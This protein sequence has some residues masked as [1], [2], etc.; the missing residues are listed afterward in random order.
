MAEPFQIT[1]RQIA[2]IVVWLAIGLGCSR[3]AQSLPERN[4]AVWFFLVAWIVPV[5]GVIGVLLGRH[6]VWVLRGIVI[7][8][9][10]FGLLMPAWD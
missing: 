7:A 9:L 6:A 4:I 10:A 3:L 8:A 2:A 1:L 5:C